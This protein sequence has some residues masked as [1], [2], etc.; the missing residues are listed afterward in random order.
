MLP[1]NTLILTKVLDET[2]DDP[3][4][5]LTFLSQENN[6]IIELVLL[7]KFGRVLVVCDTEQSAQY[8]RQMILSSSTWGKLSVSFSMRS[9]NFSKEMT[10]WLAAKTGEEQPELD[11]L[12]L[13]LEDGSKR[14][15]ISPPLSPPPE[16]DLWDKV[17][18]G[19]NQKAVY[20]ADDISHLLWER[21]GGLQSSTVRKYQET[22][23]SK[24]YDMKRDPEVLFQ[25]IHN[26]APAIV[27]DGLGPEK[28]ADVKIAKTAMPPID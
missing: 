4:E 7:P 11:F 6:H 13:P 23:E 5:L 19:P 17:E 10:K 1:T 25:D 15:L 27:L 9:N 3:R 26:G 18:E 14:F 24:S 20:S 2:L 12:E 22:D 8:I 16:W 21:L 28:K